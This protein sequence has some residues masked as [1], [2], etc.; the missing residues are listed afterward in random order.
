MREIGPD[1]C[2]IFAIFPP[3]LITDPSFSPV[4]RW[5]ETR[6]VACVARSRHNRSAG[7]FAAARSDCSLDAG[8]LLLSKRYAAFRMSQLPKVVQC[9]EPIFKC[10]FSKAR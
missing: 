2:A 9:G 10:K 6:L 1:C 5:S 3:T 8:D 4:S 7:G